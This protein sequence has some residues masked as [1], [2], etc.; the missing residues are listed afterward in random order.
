MIIQEEA[1]QW[2]MTFESKINCS[3]T[4][5]TMLS[6]ATTMCYLTLRAFVILHRSWLFVFDITN[7][8]FYY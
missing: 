2:V 8:Y 3:V 7:L 5:V 4:A 6:P 1:Q